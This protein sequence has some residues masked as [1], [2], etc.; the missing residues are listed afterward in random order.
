MFKDRI[1]DCYFCE[2]PPRLFK[3]W[4]EGDAAPHY[5]IQCQECETSSGEDE[6][7]SRHAAIKFWN[8]MIKRMR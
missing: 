8:E 1:E 6:F 2:T 5:Y 7:F 4:S 3:I